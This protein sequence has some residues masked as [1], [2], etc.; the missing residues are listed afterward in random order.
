M[1]K[2]IMIFLAVVVFLSGTANAQSPGQGRMC[3]MMDWMP[4]VGI[5]AEELPERD[6]APAKAYAKFCGQCHALPNPSQHSKEDWKALVERMDARMKM[7]GEHGGMMMRRRGMMHDQMRG[8]MNVTA[9][10]AEEM[11]AILEYL[12]RH[13]MRTIKEP[14]KLR[15]ISGFAEFKRTCSQCHALPDPSLHTEDEWPDVVNR[16]ETHH[17]QRGL[18][19]IPEKDKAAIVTFLGNALKK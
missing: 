3:G 12:Q 10:T 11:S 5:S 8:M 17:M 14:E 18:G 19:N 2:N 13:S 1:L 16:M 4:Q 6:S 7:M 15:I 9:M